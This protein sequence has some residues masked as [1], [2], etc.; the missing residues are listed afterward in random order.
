MILLRLTYYNVH[1]ATISQRNALDLTN[2]YLEDSYITVVL[3]D[4][5]GTAGDHHTA[6]PT[7]SFYL[8]RGQT[9]IINFHT[10]C[11]LDLWGN[12]GDALLHPH[13]GDLYAWADLYISHGPLQPP[14]SS[15]RLLSVIHL[16]GL[17]PHGTEVFRNLVLGGISPDSPPA[18]P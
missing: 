10:T 1:N 13:V 2:T 15:Q 3:G 16:D 8:R 5:E 4:V 17:R 18:T 7:L 9:T 14:H 12:G 11:Y 6:N